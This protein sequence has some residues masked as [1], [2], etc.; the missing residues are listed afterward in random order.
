LTRV[1]A[2]SPPHGEAHARLNAM[3]ALTRRL[4]EGPL[5][6]DGGMGSFLYGR[7]VG[8]DP[9]FDALNINQP[10][11]VQSVHT[12]YIAVGADAIETNTF[13]ANRFKLAAFGFDD[14]VRRI[15]I[16]RAR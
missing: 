7:G 14:H 1:I 6:C 4:S 13:G 15:H 9:C 11:L 8:L 12:E 5:L 3:H 10:R 2:S 16:Q